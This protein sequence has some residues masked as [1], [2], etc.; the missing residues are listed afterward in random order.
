MGQPPTPLLTAPRVPLVVTAPGQLQTPPATVH[1]VPHQA[2]LA[3]HLPPTR[4]PTAPLGQASAH[5]G[6]GR[7]VVGRG[8]T[9]LPTAPQP[10]TA[11]LGI[12]DLPTI[13]I[14]QS[15]PNLP[16]GCAIESSP[17]PLMVSDAN[18]S[19]QP[20]Q[21]QFVECLARWR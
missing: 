9:R 20:N 12:M 18:F 5:L 10:P 13:E 16:L 4:Q 19:V 17:L 6:P 3:D 8:Q 2:G 21:L 14:I 1:R 7:A 11:L 15:V